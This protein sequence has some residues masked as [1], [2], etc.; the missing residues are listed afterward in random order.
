MG[1][2]GRL[3]IPL[4]GR[5]AGQYG[6]LGVTGQA[7]LDGVLAL[8][9]VNGYAPRQGDTFTFLAANGGVSGA[10]DSVEISG[11]L[12]GFDYDLN[13][14]NGEVILEA[15]NDGVPFNLIFLPMAVR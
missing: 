11:L 3:E 14:A 13:V 5:G 6:S 10:F 7:T 8:R 2:T 12:P 4:A 15:L 1:P 9:F